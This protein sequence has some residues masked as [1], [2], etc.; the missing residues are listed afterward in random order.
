[1]NPP[2]LGDDAQRATRLA[3]QV[4]RPINAHQWEGIQPGAT[5][6]ML[7]SPGTKGGA[8]RGPLSWRTARVRNGGVARSTIS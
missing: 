8:S 1:M 7:V 3:D 2:S 6:E 5:L 4:P